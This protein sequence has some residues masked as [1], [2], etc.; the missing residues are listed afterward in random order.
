MTSLPDTQTSSPPESLIPVSPSTSLT[1]YGAFVAHRPRLIL[2]FFALALTVMGVL[3]AGLFPRLA[4]GGF[5]DPGSESGRAATALAEKFDVRT[6]VAVV[7]VEMTMGIDSAAADASAQELVASLE[8][9]SGVSRV[10]S[11]WT[12]GRPDA[13]R[14][15]D[16]RTGQLIVDSNLKAGEIEALAEVIMTQITAFDEANPDLRAFMG[17]APAVNADF[18]SSITSDLKTA[19]LIAIPVQFVLLLIVFGTLVAAGLPFLVAAGSIVGSFFVVWLVSLTT[20][21]SIFSLNLITALG[22]G[23]GIDYALLIVTRFR[24]E[25]H[26]VNGAAPRAPQ[27]AVVRTVATAGRTVLFSGVTVVVVLAAML[28][29]PQYFLRSFGYAGVAA[30]L[31]AMGAAL[32]ALPAALSLA[33]YRIDRLRVLRRDLRPRDEGAWSRIAHAVMR[34]PVAVALVTVIALAALAVPV[35]GARF[36][37]S[38]QRDLPDGAPSKVAATVLADR[39]TGQQ[40]SPIDVVLPGQ[41]DRSAQ[42]QEYAARVSQVP[43]I[44]SVTT[45]SAVLVAGAVVTPNPRPEGFVAGADV[46]LRAVADVGSRTSAGED[47]IAAVRAVP[48]P[49]DARLI[50]G[51]GADFV[52]SQAAINDRGQWAL[53]WVVLATLIVLFLFTGSVVLPIKAVLLNAASLISTLGVLVW[54][55]QDGNGRWLVGDFTVT[56]HVDTSMAVLIAVIVFALSMDYEVFL[57]SRI[58][59]EHR[60]GIATQDAVAIGLQRSGRVITAAAVLLAVVFAAFVTS[61]VTTIKMLGLGVAFAIVVDAFVVRA[62]LVPALMRLMDQWNW[63]APAPLAWVYRRIGLRDE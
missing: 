59:E 6:P 56:G 57:V 48:A 21:V 51:V 27:D 8:S 2:G 30:T 10:Q 26:G 25:L 14:G 63:W 29:F 32:T 11:Y 4:G 22:L 47:L 41:G 9:V 31:L 28:F 38:D 45:A 5:D 42:V 37:Q 15:N 61:G 46:R 18:S 40:G 16:E 44:T 7:A 33:G 12:S 52:D 55:F 19:E 43:G 62:L 1:R 54:V 20:D 35:L 49:T 24:E 58:A 50:G 36:S 39:F 34:R 60:R 3:G 53:V 23:L 17:G 13:L